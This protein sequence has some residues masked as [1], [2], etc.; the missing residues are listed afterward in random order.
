MYPEILKDHIVMVD[1]DD[2]PA[3]TS[4]YRCLGAAVPL[5]REGF[6]DDNVLEEVPLVHPQGIT[7]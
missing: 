5:D 7:R 3:P 6:V 2:I 4:V 1:N